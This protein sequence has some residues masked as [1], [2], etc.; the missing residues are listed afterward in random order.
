MNNNAGKSTVVAQ[1][2]IYF[3]SLKNR[4]PALGSKFCRHRISTH[5][6]NIHRSYGYGMASCRKLNIFVKRCIEHTVSFQS[7]SFPAVKFVFDGSHAVVVPGNSP[8]EHQTGFSFNCTSL[9]RRLNRYHRLV[10]F[11]ID[12][13]DLFYRNSVS[14]SVQ[15]SNGKF[16]LFG[17]KPQGVNFLIPVRV[18]RHKFKFPGL[19]ATRPGQLLNT[20]F[21]LGITGHAKTTVHHLAVIRRNNLYVRLS[22]VNKI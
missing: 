12:R 20:D 22:I 2:R 7:F 10:Q 6:V 11:L 18:S 16:N 9:N 17:V 15:S 13:N 14:G 4:C 3:S 21:V 1:R 8:K 19:I 5:T